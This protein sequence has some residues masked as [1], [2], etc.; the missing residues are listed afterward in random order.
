MGKFVL[1]HQLYLNN[2]MDTGTTLPS[3]IASVF[4]AI[5]TNNADAIS[6]R[7]TG[8]AAMKTQFTRTGVHGPWG[9][10]QDGITAAER[11]L[12]QT[13]RDPTKQ[14]SIN[15][16][17][18]K[19]ESRR[20]HA[21]PVTA[22]ADGLVRLKVFKRSSWKTMSVEYSVAFEIHSTQVVIYDWDNQK[23]R[24]YRLSSLRQVLPSLSEPCVLVLMFDS[25]VSPK[26]LRFQSPLMRQRVIMRLLTLAEH[27]PRA[28]ADVQTDL[29]VFTGSIDMQG[30]GACKDITAWLRPGCDLYVVSLTNA[31]FPSPDDFVFFGAQYF[32]YLVL[33]ALGGEYQ[34][35]SRSESATGDAMLV[36]CRA[37]LRSRLASLTSISW[38][39]RTMVASD[40]SW[41][42]R[43]SRATSAHRAVARSKSSSQL[44]SS[45]MQ[46][47]RRRGTV[48]IQKDILRI[49]AS[50]RIG[51]D[52]TPLRLVH[53]WDL[54]SAVPELE[55]GGRSIVTGLFKSES[56]S[57]PAN[58]GQESGT[59]VVVYEN[60]AFPDAK[61]VSEVE[62]GVTNLVCNVWNPPLE[63]DAAETEVAA[64]EADTS[65]AAAAAAAG[66]DGGVDLHMAT[67]ASAA[68]SE[69]TLT[70]IRKSMQALPA[71]MKHGGMVLVGAPL[72]QGRKTATPADTVPSSSE[73]APAETRECHAVWS[74]FTLRTSPILH[75][76]EEQTLE[77]RNLKAEW[78]AVKAPP[79]KVVISLASSV[80]KEQRAQSIASDSGTWALVNGR[81][82]TGRL[83]QVVLGIALTGFAASSSSF[84]GF[85][86]TITGTPQQLAISRLPLAPLF[87][88]SDGNFRIPLYAVVQDEPT[89]AV[90]G[91]LSGKLVLVP[92]KRPIS[93]SGDLID[94]K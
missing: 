22:A 33:N 31:I 66:P 21:L 39:T 17:L 92:S 12:E 58:F 56:I 94:L 46:P 70:A 49:G 20:M 74:C 28:L 93:S 10:L 75:A 88:E 2:L 68:G 15:L 55:L 4:N 80:F 59:R 43:A 57:G 72:A 7:Y 63:S 3:E 85:L 83:Q 90:Y 84:A 44:G 34:C 82:W 47:I 81:V 18:G 52:E 36:V 87:D 86:G 40:P 26:F 48:D 9:Q 38:L 37:S 16:L 60:S 32:F 35:V 64:N 23:S 91:H 67:D 62:G 76:V 45:A 29:R 71:V 61:Q 41:L 19:E 6:Q 54:G 8:A 27:V 78:S 42:A 1:C 50:L 30:C 51:F 11:F 89:G 25:S 5:W 65:A 14:D 53:M 24:T 73:G 77:L 13:L 79:S 69:L